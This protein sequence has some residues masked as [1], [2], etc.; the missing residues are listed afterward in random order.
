MLCLC[1][2][3]ILHFLLSTD[4]QTQ[5]WASVPTTQVS[6]NTSDC[7]C[8]TPHSHVRY[9][10]QNSIG[11]ICLSYQWF[12]HQCTSLF[13]SAEMSPRPSFTSLCLCVINPPFLQSRACAKL[14]QPSQLESILRRGRQYLIASASQNSTADRSNW[15]HAMGSTLSQPAVFPS[16]AFM[17]THL[18]LVSICSSAASSFLWSCSIQCS[19]VLPGPSQPPLYVPAQRTSLCPLVLLHPVFFS[20]AWAFTTIALC[21][22]TENFS[23]P[24]MELTIFVV[25]SIDAECKC[26]ADSIGSH[27]HSSPFHVCRENWVF[28]CSEMLPPNTVCQNFLLIVSHNGANASL[29]FGTTRCVST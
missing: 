1:C 16:T 27:I 20:F 28:S 25:P 29:Q 13:V 4:R 26:W 19:S 2:M 12:P 21:S 3:R 11:L 5:D 8:H 22:S 6:N 7:C 10:G 24:L 23:L 17:T 15:W 9:E 14:P 18:F